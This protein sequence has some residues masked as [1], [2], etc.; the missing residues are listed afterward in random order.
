[1]SKFD[2][3]DVW[4]MVLCAAVCL[5]ALG[6]FSMKA[7]AW[8]ADQNLAEAKADCERLMIEMFSAGDDLY[9]QV[10]S[11]EV[12]V[13]TVRS[14]NSS[15]TPMAEDIAD[16]ILSSRATWPTRAAEL[17]ARNAFTGMMKHI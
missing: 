17:C 11:R 14:M 7:E 13:N 5:I 1:M 10:H 6:L 2:K 8:S 12:L 3:L 9:R 4:A 15:L 16:A